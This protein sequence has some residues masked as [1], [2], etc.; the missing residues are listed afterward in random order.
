MS[1]TRDGLSDK[2]INRRNYPEAY[3][4]LI[5]WGMARNQKIYLREKG[6]F[7][8]QFLDASL[9]YVKRVSP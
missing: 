1:L 4:T 3:S 2:I 8:E 6:E 7:S 5:A 9:I